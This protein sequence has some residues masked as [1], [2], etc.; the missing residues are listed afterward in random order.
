MFV[1]KLI[2][3]VCVAFLLPATASLAQTSA[4]QPAPAATTTS[5]PPGGMPVFIRTETPQQR[6]DRL[7]IQE[8]PG[9]NP[10]PNKHYWR[11]GHSQHIER[12]DRKWAVYDQPQGMVRPFGNANIAFEIYQQNDQYVWT[13][14]LDPEPVAPDAEMKEV[15]R[16]NRYNQATL[17]FLKKERPQYAALAP[18]A[19]EKVIHFREASN[20]LPNRG[21]W[22]NS[23]AVAD[24]NGDGCPDI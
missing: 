2:I 1:R 4:P 6:K 21:S 17:D 11:F 16:A 12:F 7:G 3:A 20:G 18:T 5:V 23:L 19:S 24:M 22:R 13:W 10:D 8:D 9:I 15:Q 14:V